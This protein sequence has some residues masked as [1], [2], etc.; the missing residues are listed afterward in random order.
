[1]AYVYGHYKADTDELFYIGK[2]TGKRAWSNG[3]RNTYWHNVVNKHGYTVRILE[4][5]LTDE[6][7]FSKEIELIN[8]HKSTLVNIAEGG[9]GHTSKTAKEVMS[10]P[11][12]KKLLSD[13]SK[14]LWKDPE[15]RQKTLAAFTDEY[16]ERVTNSNKKTWSDPVLL[17]EH[18]KRTKKLWEN[19]EYH[20]VISEKTKAQRAREI[21]QMSIDEKKK[22]SVRMS[23]NRWKNKTPEERAAHSRMMYEAR[24]RKKASSNPNVPTVDKP[25]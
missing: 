17:E 24:L 20:K 23:E 9:I 13:K 6:D 7:A 8:E 18:S 25:N 16:I 11:G 12:M 1:M 21:A 15:Y 19:P 22:V 4:N 10:R 3:N 5:G 2:G 14:E